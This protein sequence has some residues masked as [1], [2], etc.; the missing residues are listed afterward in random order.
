MEDGSTSTVPWATNVIRS[1]CPASSAV[2]TNAS[3]TIELN[4]DGTLLPVPYN[5]CLMDRQSGLF[6]IAQKHTHETRA[7]GN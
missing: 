3:L 4:L 1:S 2:P 5:Q 6:S 7:L